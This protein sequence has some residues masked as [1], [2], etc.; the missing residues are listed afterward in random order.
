MI[1]EY[2]SG[3]VLRELR[4]LWLRV[5]SCSLIFVLGAKRFGTPRCLRRER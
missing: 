1:L 3:Y 5:L 4:I 2:P